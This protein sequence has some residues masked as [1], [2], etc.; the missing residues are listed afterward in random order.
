MKNKSRA[1]TLIELLVVVLII[2]IL[3]AVA[4]PQYQ[5]AV[6]NA[7]VAKLK[8]LVES[9]ANAAE[10]YYLANQE[11]PYKDITLLDVQFPPGSRI[12][13]SSTYSKMEYEGGFCALQVTSDDS[14]AVAVNCFD[15]AAGMI[16]GKYSANYSTAPNKHYCCG[17][18]KEE[19]FAVCKNLFSSANNFY[20]GR[21]IVVGSTKSDV[22]CYRER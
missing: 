4:V 19:S 3:A 8:P 10:T 9:V 20:N 1:F 6:V 5:K 14:A 17:I 11:Y 13:S 12:S 16:Y 22:K 21:E 18:D 15:S 2:G 7:R